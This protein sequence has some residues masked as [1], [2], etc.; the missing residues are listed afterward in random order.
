MRLL[1]TILV[2]IIFKDLLPYNLPLIQATTLFKFNETSLYFRIP[3]AMVKQKTFSPEPWFRSSIKDDAFTVPLSMRKFAQG[4][5]TINPFSHVGT[6]IILVR[7]WVEIIWVWWHRLHFTRTVSF[8]PLV[9]LLRSTLVTNYS[10]SV[11]SS[12]TIAA[13][14]KII[15]V[16]EQRIFKYFF[17]FFHSFRFYF[18]I[19][20]PKCGKRLYKTLYLKSMKNLHTS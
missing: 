18:V 8:K 13:S 3:H 2:C 12:E 19:P 5:L 11:R 14:V 1:R 16:K 20:W 6:Q 7:F 9:D 15:Y 17:L 10:I 4:G